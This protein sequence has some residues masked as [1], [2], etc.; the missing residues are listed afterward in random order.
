MIESWEDL[1]PD[2]DLPRL[3]LPKKTD[4]KV[5]KPPRDTQT[6]IIPADSPL[7][8]AHPFYS[9]QPTIRILSR[10]T[11]SASP[12]S[13]PKDDKN[14]SQ[15]QAVKTIEEREKEYAAARAKIFNQAPST[16]DSNIQPNSYNN[17]NNN[18]INNNNNSN[19]STPQ[20]FNNTNSTISSNNNINNNNNN[21]NFTIYEKKKTLFDANSNSTNNGNNQ[22]STKWKNN[23]N[24]TPNGKNLKN[25]P[26][27]PDGTKGFYSESGKGRGKR[28]QS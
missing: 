12:T 16:V 22:V 1:D 23:I 11:N 13:S 25:Q 17:I 14:N 2:N 4:T 7:R 5:S 6:Q 24:P 27:N 9:S 3:N 26:L 20:N 21:N 15:S 8:E 18:N 28:N 10:N 19:N